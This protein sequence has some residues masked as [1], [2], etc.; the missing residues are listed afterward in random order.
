ME[1]ELE[2][3][4]EPEFDEPEP[5]PDFDEPEPDFDAPDQEDQ[6]ISDMDVSE[7]VIEPSLLDETLPADISLQETT[8]EIIPTGSQRGKPL[9]VDS[10]GYI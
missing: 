3:P 7:E 2:E 5:E 4:M 10:L 8:Y 1:P 6:D 9:L